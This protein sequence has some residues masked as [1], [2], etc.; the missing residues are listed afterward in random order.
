MNQKLIFVLLML[1]F[2]LNQSV[3]GAANRTALV[4]GNSSYSSIT[5]LPNPVNDATDMTAALKKLGFEVILRTN[6]NRSSIREAVRVFGD[7]IKKGGVG[8]F[9]YAGHGVQVEGTNYMIPVDVDIKRKY[10]IEDQGLKMN[11]VLGAMQ[12]ANNKL[13]II[14]LDACRDNPFR[15]FRG[16][17]PGLARMDAPTGS[18]IAYAT[19]PGGKAAD[20]QG[21]N[22]TYTAQLLK[23][24][25]NPAL[26]VQEMLNQTGLS[27]MKTTN[28]DQVP[29]ISSTPV[30]KYYLAGGSSTVDEPSTGKGKMSIITDPQGADIFVNNQF[31]GKAP[32]VINSMN[33]V[34]YRVMARL[35][36][37]DDINKKIKVNTN[38]KAIAT[39]YFKKQESKGRLYV[40][41]NPSDCIVKILNI[42]PRYRDG[43]ELDPGAYKIQ[44]SKA[45]YTTKIKTIQIPSSEGVDFYVELEK[46]AVSS[47]I[48]S[49]GTAGSEQT[50]TDPVTGMEFVSVPAVCYQ[51]GSNSGSSDEKPV[52]EVCLDGFWMAKHEVTNRQYRMFK[53]GHSSKDYKGVTLNKDDQPV[54]Y[55][56]WN[57]AKAFIRWLNRK[58]GQ[59]FALPTEAQWEYAARAGTRT[60]RYWGDNPDDACRYANVH[61][62][63]SK[64]KF[65]NFTWEKHNCNDGYAGTA[66]V[67]SFI[68][69]DFGLYDMLGNVWEWCEDVY[70]KNAYSKYSRNNSVITSGGNSR[71]DRG[72]SWS[73]SPRCV[74]AA[75]RSRGTAGYRGNNL[76]F[77]LCLSQVRQ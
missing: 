30:K 66:P 24:L 17:S 65:S 51:M 5:P 13:N 68:P 8:L 40:T 10:D 46:Q 72:G 60:I 2:F 75:Y 67:G 6:A 34:T 44:V 19:A 22:G 14:I 56:A 4:I 20:G 62:H 74:R 54:V 29:W 76:G 32:L 63:T 23:H 1:V 3:A 9:Y 61:D 18:I 48:S 39:F 38:R 69:N 52:H 70:D 59:E 35:K 49:S 45:G 7:K 37:H 55:V 64:N 43:I 36:G 50:W 57:E 42:I 58:T 21:R 47:G 71:V 11:Y 77:R 16:S 31:K 28:N 33:P 15:S 53:S 25:G 73:N 26:S 12:D 41:T 27:V